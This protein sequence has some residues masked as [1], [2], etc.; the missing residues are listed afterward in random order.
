MKTKHIWTPEQRQAAAV[1]MK[2]VQEKRWAKSEDIAPPRHIAPEVQ[3]VLDT[4]TPERKAKLAMIQSRTMNLGNGRADGEATQAAL[5]RFEAEKQAN[6]VLQ[7]TAPL[8]PIDPATG[9]EPNPGRDAGRIGSREV[10]LIVRTDGTMVSQYGPCVCGKQKREWHRICLGEIIEAN[11]T[12]IASA[13]NAKK[14]EAG[15]GQ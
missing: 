9:L 6:P 1:R 8:K 12:R 15:N 7:E 13:G 3:A 14:P 2:A 10:S 5:A 11:P 4:M